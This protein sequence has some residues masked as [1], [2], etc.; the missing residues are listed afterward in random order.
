MLDSLGRPRPSDDGE[1]DPRT[2]GQ[3]RHDALQ[4]A[5]LGVLR[6]GDL[7]DSGGITTTIVLTMT[8]EQ[9]RTGTGLARTGHG[10]T[11]PARLAA[12]LAGDAQVV[13][14]VL[15]SMRRI[16]A[17]SATHRIF[18]KRQRLAMAARDHGCSFPGCDLPPALCEAHHVTEFR[19]SRRTT[20]DDGTLVCG[21]H[22]REHERLGWRAVMIAGVPHW[23]PPPWI[24]PARTPR[25]NTVHDPQPHDP[26]AV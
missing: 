25:R 9:W 13:G 8:A 22:H 10:A 21:F 14:A 4:D 16:E 20:V 24:D 17:Y 5:L 15:D 26:H 11:V 3:R 19:E 12:S 18:T 1:R 2:A 6:T 23:V 7:P